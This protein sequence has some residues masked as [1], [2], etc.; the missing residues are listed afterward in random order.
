[1]PGNKLQ[2]VDIENQT[3]WSSYALLILGAG[4]LTLLG[5]LVFVSFLKGPMPEFAVYSL[6]LLSA[7]AGVATFFSPCSFPLLPGY[8]SLYYVS[9][10]TEETGRPLRRGAPAALGVVT[11]NVLL[12]LLIATLGGGFASSLSI[13]NSNPNQL[14]L[15]LRIGVGAVLV[16]LGIVQP[17]NMT[18]HNHTFDSIAARLFRPSATGGRALYLY[19]LG[20][21]TAGI[22]CAGPIMAGLVVFALGL[23]GFEDALAAFLVYSVT[24][25]SLMIV[26]SI[27]TARSKTE[28]L[29]GLKRSTVRIKKAS[30]VVML[31]VGAFLIYA[32]LDLQLLLS[33]FPK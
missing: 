20:Y 10:E 27:I 16:S 3:S 15:A 4:I 33:F 25:A 12:G 23:G 32:T 11:F 26:I 22:G 8:L 17:S 14:T 31:C 9:D 29:G 19:G 7:V 28:L 2:V 5:Y 6:Y 1:M 21:S 24:M 13:S 30:S 18:F